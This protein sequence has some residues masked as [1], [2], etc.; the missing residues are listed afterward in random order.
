MFIQFLN[1][2]IL[3]GLMSLPGYKTIITQFPELIQPPLSAIAIYAIFI[4]APKVF[5]F[6]FMGVNDTRLW[7]ESI[8]DY[9]GI[10]L[11]SV[12]KG[13]GEYACEMPFSADKETGK[14]AVIPEESRFNQ[15]LVVGPSGSR[16]NISCF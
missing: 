15:L 8:W 3:V 16:K 1:S 2:G 13:T 14:K 11:T 6:L 10:K 12:T 4:S 5:D 7:Q 9:G